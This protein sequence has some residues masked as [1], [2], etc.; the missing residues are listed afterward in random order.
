M[1]KKVK[2][3]E[4]KFLPFDFAIKVKPFLL[5]LKMCGRGCFNLH[6]HVCMVNRF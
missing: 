4:H 3:F 1:I 5:I 6:T 2:S